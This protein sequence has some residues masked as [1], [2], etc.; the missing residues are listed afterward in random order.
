MVA[1]EA[2]GVSLK[3]ILLPYLIVSILVSIGSYYFNDIIVP[4]SNHKAQV[5]MR[6]YVYKKGEIKPTFHFYPPLTTKTE[7]TPPNPSSIRR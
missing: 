1:I 3:R 7:L 2:C 4:E 6:E 5:L